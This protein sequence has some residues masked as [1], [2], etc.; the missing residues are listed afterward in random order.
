MDGAHS[1]AANAGCNWLCVLEKLPH[2]RALHFRIDPSAD[3]T[4]ADAKFWLDCL[5]QVDSAYSGG[6][7]M[8]ARSIMLAGLVGTLASATSEARPL[9]DILSP[10]VVVLP[11]PPDPA[12]PIRDRLEDEVNRALGA[13]VHDSGSKTSQMTVLRGPNG[14]FEYYLWQRTSWSV[15]EQ[16]TR[17]K[18]SCHV[19][20]SAWVTSTRKIRGRRVNVDKI[21]IDAGD[22]G[23]IIRTNASDA[24]V[25]YDETGSI[26]GRHSRG[27]FDSAALRTASYCSA[28]TVTVGPNVFKLAAFCVRKNY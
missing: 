18:S 27:C 4:T 6:G 5:P 11:S 23:L 3:G 15:N 19:A 10:P 17:A 25:K 12:E 8:N 24:Q 9:R 1:A 28:V 16:L 13:V 21:R 14:A 2:S 26:I 22:R 7:D 20:Y